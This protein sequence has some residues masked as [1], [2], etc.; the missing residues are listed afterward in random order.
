MTAL[1]CPVP[2]IVSTGGAVSM[3]NVCVRKALRVRTAGSELAP[4]TAMAV[5]SV[6]TAVVCASLASAVRTAVN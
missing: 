6:S 2:T 4:Q 5:G 1:S 3:V